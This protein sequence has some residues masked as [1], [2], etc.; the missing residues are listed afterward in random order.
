MQKT[1][2]STYNIFNSMRLRSIVSLL[3]LFLTIAGF[4]ASAQ[5]SG[6]VMDSEG[7]PLTGATVMVVG[8]SIGTSADIDGN[9]TI[10]A[11]PGQSLRVTSVG[12]ETAT[13]K[14]AD[15]KHIEIVLRE[16][17]TL[18]KDV[19]VVGYGTME[20]KRVTSSITS[21]KGDDLMTGLGGSTIATAL[22]GKVSGL[23]ISGSASPNSS[24]GYQ[25]RGVAS[26]NAGQSPLVVID[27]VPGGDLRIINQED[28]ES[29][30]VLKD[31]SAGAIY[32]TRAAAGVILV[33][34]K[35]AQ[36][37]KTR[38][39]Y[40][41][42]L[43]TEN[44]R[45]HLETL[46]SQ[47]YVEYGIG[48]DYGYDTDW[49]KAMTN[50][51]AFSQRHSLSISGGSKNLQM[52][53]S[54]VYSDQNGVVIGDS[55]KD[56][57]ARL[58]GKYLM[59]DGKVEI[60][61][62]AQYRE[63]DRDNRNGTY[64]FQQAL[65]LNP[66]IPLMDPDAPA[67]YNVSGYGLS[68]TSW[69]PVADVMLKSS[70]GKDKWFLG[71]AT[72]KVNL[73]DGLSVQGTMGIDQ[74]QYQKY[75]YKT[76][77]HRECVNSNKRGIATHSFDKTDNKS[78]EAYA[79]YIKS[80]NQV[81]RFDAVAGWSFWETNGESFNMQNSNFS[82]DGLGAWDMS[83]GTDLKEGQA[84]MDSSKD[85][86]E[87][88]ISY[89]ARANYSYDDKYMATAS[90]RREGSSKF[91][92]RNRW[93]DFWSLSAG[94]RISK[95]NFMEELPW[96]NDLKLRVGYGVTGNNDFGS[97]YTVRMY[98][99]GTEGMWAV[100][101]IWQNAYGTTINMNPDLKWEQKKELNFGVDYS[102][103]DNRIYGKFDIYKRRVDDMLYQVSAP[104]LP[105]VHSVL[106]TNIGSLTNDGWEF[107]IS[108]DIFRLKDFSWTST[109][110]M[111]HNTSRI[112]NLGSDDSVLL[113]DAFPSSMGNASRIVN[114]SE[115]G[116]FWLFKHAGLDADGKWLIYDK[117]NNIVS[118][119]AENLNN[120]NKH[121]V[122]NGIPK[123]IMSMDNNFRYKDFDLGI[124]LRSW[125]DYDV[126]SQLNLYHGLKQ[127][128]SENVL[129]IAY[130]DNAAIN[131]KRILSDY[132]LSDGT[133]LKIDALTLGYTLKLSK[134][135]KFVQKM[136][137]YVT[138]RDLY[139]FTKYKGYNP[140]VSINGLFPGIEYVLST[141]TMYPQ[142][143]RWTFG[144]QLTF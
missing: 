66:T 55:R 5:V 141:S 45:K 134:Y 80:F 95:E 133:F 113:G 129:K 35:R 88:L 90:Y 122:G 105:M 28:I 19:V 118:A 72:L 32:G 38:V 84:T 131:D 132:F 137:A 10:N 59:Y 42:E 41:M 92:P 71:D 68:T 33:T 12:Y 27:G 56:Y 123:L 79:T 82:V 24:N 109:L 93:G 99:V 20:K 102:F 143:T 49:Y 69:N 87:R 130:T 4:S 15:K 16:N 86:R 64:T 127:S 2:K 9:F 108:G 107:E 51:N 125:I 96:V 13:V 120:D 11:T 1:M 37:G 101:G 52:Y 144:L 53:S 83:A 75:T 54:L 14:I 40:T 29:I 8:T 57:S 44:V 61:V 119:T 94:W 142:T 128:S 50:D 77:E 140:E 112:K 46:S 111:S 60:G 43:S 78:F 106:M 63:A 23:T 121:Y 91:G 18:L 116:K 7:E 114:G 31:A 124:S 34:T 89:F 6:S 48:Q 65:T 22:Q 97:G 62:K 76:F 135:N 67:K 70:D 36:E 136:R 47:E 110:R 138:A 17:A 98:A 103:L 115:I 100:N 26:V 39:T 21:I 58:N 126:F 81:H 85:P 25:L 104:V 117:D 74:R 30:D 139:T 3:M 73:I